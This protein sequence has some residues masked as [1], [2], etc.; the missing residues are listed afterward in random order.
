[1]S[2]FRK[3]RADNP[4]YPQNAIIRT[5]PIKP[6]KRIK[7][8]RGRKPKG[9]KL[10][11]RNLSQF[12]KFHTEAARNKARDTEE[13]KR[14]QVVKDRD[15]ARKEKTDRLQIEDRRYAA[16]VITDARDK[17][18][19]RNFRADQLRLL[20]LQVGAAGNQ[21]PINIGAPAINVAAPP[22]AQIIFQDR[23]RGADR[24]PPRRRGSFGG[25]A[26]VPMSRE[27]Q[28]EARDAIYRG[29]AG[30]ER[31]Q[32]RREADFRE[33]TQ[34]DIRT[35]IR[36]A[37]REFGLDPSNLASPIPERSPSRVLP[38][39]AQQVPVVSGINPQDFAR[40]VRDA[41]AARNE[42]LRERSEREALA[43]EVEQ[44]Q[45]DRDAE[46]T[47]AATRELE[48]E[49][50]ARRIAE[51]GATNLQRQRQAGEEAVSREREVQER[52]S[53]ERTR[54]AL[55]QRD[56]EVAEGSA[57]RGA[58][59]QE[60]AEASA[61]NLKRAQKAEGQVQD[62][63]AAH[64]GVATQR[65][66]ALRQRDTLRA[67]QATVAADARQD[68]YEDLAK[69]YRGLILSRASEAD[70]RREGFND[71]LEKETEKVRQTGKYPLRPTGGKPVS[72]YTEVFY[73]SPGGGR[74]M[75]KADKSPLSVL[76]S[77]K[78]RERAI[79]GETE[80]AI[81][82][83]GGDTEEEELEEARAN[84]QR[85]RVP[86]D[87]PAGINPQFL[88]DPESSEEE[89]EPARR[90]SSRKPP[91]SRTKAQKEAADEE[92]DDLATDYDRPFGPIE[93]DPDFDESVGPKSR[94]EERRKERIG[95]GRA[96]PSDVEP[97]PDVDDSLELEPPKKKGL[98]KLEG[99][100][101]FFEEI[102][103]GEGRPSG[104]EFHPNLK[105]G[106]RHNRVFRQE[107]FGWAA[108]VMNG[109]FQGKGLT[110]ADLPK[111]TAKKG[112]RGY[113]KKVWK[114]QREDE[115]PHS[116]VVKEDLTSKEVGRKLPAGTYKF[117]QYGKRGSSGTGQESFNFFQE[118]GD[119]GTAGIKDTSGTGKSEDF[120]LNIHQRRGDFERLAQEGKIEFKTDTKKPTPKAQVLDESVES[121]YLAQAGGAVVGGA[122]AAGGVMGN[123]ALGVARGVG[124]AVYDRLPSAGDV[125]QAIGGGA[126]AVGSGVVGIVRGGI[127]QALSPRPAPAGEQTGGAIPA[128]IL[129][130]QEV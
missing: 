109:D 89:E 81:E 6:F 31:D 2:D 106:K 46:R 107:E 61:R 68:V 97:E 44:Q 47:V 51:E 127:N 55:A 45:R 86:F 94:I 121:G 113:S 43:Q 37:A 66:A 19:E 82:L 59:E 65:D 110:D 50:E 62:G 5:E 24:S 22:P 116:L 70:K 119:H 18:D 105:T 120:Q 49:E 21:P 91:P 60:L 114:Q 102:P 78:G 34:R 8:R 125:G 100:E 30:G 123:A 112:G 87:P 117:R 88:D 40:E 10:Q 11:P 48:L 122:A 7:G 52:A 14:L 118:R 104:G 108:D 96:L 98:V 35:G 95:G 16:K 63:I 28:Q 69:G 29:L 38:P 41:E 72:P 73:L 71:R 92:P 79:K 4:I 39:S 20:R 85:R 128:G 1:M 53:E 42:A 130:E 54:A 56:R 99:H 9:K 83:E 103:E 23:G 33:Q 64:Q 25:G 17:R 115:I 3:P 67:A 93:G 32:A 129:D 77:P 75:K 12:N 36:Q 101:G 57:A 80:L 13:S 124:G 111:D 90:S 27:E 15:D 76:Q 126:V 84:E 74:G 58:G 26:S